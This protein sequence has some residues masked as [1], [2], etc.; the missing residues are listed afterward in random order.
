MSK[1]RFSSLRK[2]K[3]CIFKK[4][5]LFGAADVKLKKGTILAG[6][7]Q[8]Y[9]FPIGISLLTP[10]WKRGNTTKAEMDATSIQHPHAGAIY[11]K[12]KT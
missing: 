1:V 10:C 2:S 9:Q 8:F 6:E 4:N 3:L 11:N 5:N 12:L 7:L